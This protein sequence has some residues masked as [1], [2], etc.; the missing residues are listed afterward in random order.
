MTQNMLVLGGTRFFG[1]L[2]VEK[3]L[4]A[5]H[6]VTIAT[7]GTTEDP[8]GDRVK[9]IRVDRTDESALAAAVQG[10]YWDVVYDNICYQADEAR[11][12]IRVFTGRVGRYV[13][14]S[15]LSVYETGSAEVK[16]EQVNTAS[17]EIPPSPVGQVPY[18]EGKAQAE[19]VFF[20]EAPF[21]AAAARLP[22]VLGPH[23][24]TKRLHFHIDRIQNGTSFVMPNTQARICFIHEEEA[25][26]F[27]KWLGESGVT[28]PFNAASAGRPRLRELLAVID[29]ET[30]GRAIVLPEGPDSEGSPFGIPGDWTMD[31]SRAE[32]AGFVFRNLDDWLPD[33]VRELAGRQD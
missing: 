20:R 11:A 31:T 25:A 23:D 8:F 15:S 32:E 6:T 33:L 17:M 14:T 22:I 9:R 18:G 30:G 3:L 19:A 24:Y 12:A 29:R 13:L 26:D 1:K 4:E 5:G 27:L 2:L 10:Q 21:A 16:E 28:G 7:R